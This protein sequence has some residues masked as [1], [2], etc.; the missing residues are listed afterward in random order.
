VSRRVA[1]TLHRMRTPR[2]AAAGKFAAVLCTLVLLV[3]ACGGGPSAR[4]W[5]A[6]VC[7]ALTPWRTTIHEL[8]RSTQQ[9]MTAKTTP[10][11]A[12]E[13]LV[14]LMGGA[15]RATETARSAVEAAGA[16]DVT[17]GAA[18]HQG[19]LASLTAV[20]DA[21]GKARRTIE[22]LDTS[23]AGPFYDAVEAAVEVLH[24]EYD[25]GALDTSELA[26][27]ELQQAFDEVPECR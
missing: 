19:F 18:V 24:R 23:A 6:T 1:R 20:R 14:R 25:A 4:V 15:E 8:T 3:P 13:N 27:V 9:Q 26:S 21:Y 17:G 12:Q 22:E 7:S 11:Q 16:P 10:A 2:P 5:A